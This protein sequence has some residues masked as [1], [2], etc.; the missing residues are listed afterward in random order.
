MLQCAGSGGSDVG[1]TLG[2]CCLWWG[3]EQRHGERR[4]VAKED[5]ELGAAVLAG[6]VPAQDTAGLPTGEHQFL[7]WLS[8]F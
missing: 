1:W 7:E 8:L 6:D 4:R 3:L 5:E 2:F